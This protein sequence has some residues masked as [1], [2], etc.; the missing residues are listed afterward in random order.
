MKPSQ[1][2]S[3]SHFC[4]EF[5]LATRAYGDVGF[6]QQLHGQINYYCAILILI[7]AS[8]SMYAESLARDTER[9]SHGIFH[10]TW[11]LSI[12]VTI[13]AIKSLPHHHSWQFDCVTNPYTFCVLICLKRRHITCSFASFFMLKTSSSFQS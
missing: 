4:L 1:H 3:S 2:V 12:L 10:A 13:S 7:P 11:I 9:L 5:R 8:F 6:N